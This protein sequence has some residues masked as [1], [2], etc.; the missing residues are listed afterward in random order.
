MRY[1]FTRFSRPAGYKPETELYARVAAT[2]CG[3]A[4]AERS[5]LGV[6]QHQHRVTQA[7]TTQEVRPSEA[8]FN[9]DTLNPERGISYEIGLKG[10]F[11][12]NRLQADVSAYQ[13]QLRETIVRGRSAANGAEYF[14]NAGRTNQQGLETYLAYDVPLQMAEHQAV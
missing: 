11:L 3:T 6:R 12:Q 2:D 8:T 10:K 4:K 5:V 9:T 7:P 13:F 14:V 1:G